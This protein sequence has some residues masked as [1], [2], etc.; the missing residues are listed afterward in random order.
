MGKKTYSPE[1]IISYLREAEILNAKGSTI[2]QICK[3]L[4]IAEQDYIAREQISNAES[5]Q[6]CEG[7]ISG[8]QSIIANLSGSQT[9][10]GKGTINQ[11]KEALVENKELVNSIVRAAVFW[12]RDSN[13]MQ[14]NFKEIEIGIG[15]A[16]TLL[17]R[18]K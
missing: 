2:P 17:K 16:I 1:Q 11:V 9:C 8:S 12:K 6:V 10:V 7:N 13:E 14:G 4:G 15:I 18:I 3:K 5:E